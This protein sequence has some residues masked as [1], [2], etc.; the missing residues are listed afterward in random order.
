M[1]EIRPTDSNFALKSCCTLYCTPLFDACNS[2]NLLVVYVEQFPFN[3]LVASSNLA[4]PTSY[5][6]RSQQYGP[7]SFGYLECVG[8]LWRQLAI[9]ST[10]IRWELRTLGDRKRIETRH[11][12]MWF[13][14]KTDSTN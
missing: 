9:L 3:P 4:R 5:M 12:V 8:N 1:F 11:L 14:V 6:K 2:L 7:F 10:L 13:V